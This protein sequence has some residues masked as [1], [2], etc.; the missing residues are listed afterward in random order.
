MHETPA[1]AAMIACSRPVLLAILLTLAPPRPQ[2]RSPKSLP[3]QPLMSAAFDL[4]TKLKHTSSDEERAEVIAQ[5]FDALEARF[6][7]LN[8]LATQGHVREAELRLQKEIK[9][10]EA[11]L[12]KDIKDVELQIMEVEARLQKD[13]KELEARLQKDIKAL[14]LQIK[15]VDARLQERISQLEVS[16]HQALAAQTRWL[17]GGLAILGVVLKLAD[18]LIGP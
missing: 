8:D 18:V 4:Y 14:E 9:E 12:K 3:E 6:P 2:R 16:L 7:Q 10:V 5:A 13:I 1:A 15:E 17:I 11:R